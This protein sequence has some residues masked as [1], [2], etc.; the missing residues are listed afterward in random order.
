MERSSLRLATADR[1]QYA[2]A[3]SREERF[4]AAAHQYLTAAEADPDLAGWLRLSS[5]QEWA[6]AGAPDSALAVAEGLRDNP[7]VWQ[8]STFTELARAYFVA[9]DT[10]RALALVDSLSRRAKARLAAEWPVITDQ[11]DPLPEAD[12]FKD[13]KEKRELLDERPAAE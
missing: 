2:R 1:V 5:V 12:Q 7:S 11:K 8:D 9:A 6:L 13:V 10:V 4:E 3:L